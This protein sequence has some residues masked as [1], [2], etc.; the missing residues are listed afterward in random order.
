M[1]EPKPPA[2]PVVDIRVRWR[3]GQVALGLAAALSLV[4]LWRPLW[5]AR[6]GW[7]KGGYA[8]LLAS[9]VIGSALLASLRG[10]R[11]PE[12]LSLQGFL[13]LSVDAIGQLVA[14]AGLPTWPLMALLVASQAVAEGLAVALGFAGQ[15]SLLAVAESAWRT[16]HDYRLALASCA[17]Y[18]A[19][20]LVV[21]RALLGEKRRLSSALAELARLKLGIDQLDE[22][23]G[24][25]GGR[26]AAPPRRCGR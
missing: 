20:A 23:P 10:S 25:A 3:A 14:P 15:A 24:R 5:P 18:L 4:A 8:L 13:V 1:A 2:D 11:R 12:A 17:G 21:D 16:P 9:G 26:R 7:L 6:P 22:E 19:L